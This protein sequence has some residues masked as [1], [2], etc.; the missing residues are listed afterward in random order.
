MTENV[1]EILKKAVEALDS[2]K[3][4]ECIDYCEQAFSLEP[5]DSNVKIMKAVSILL[6]YSY[7][8]AIEIKNQALDV[9]KTITNTESIT[10]E[11]KCVLLDSIFAYKN[12]WEKDTTLWKR[13]S[14]YK[15]EDDGIFL[16]IMS[17]FFA[18]FEGSDNKLINYFM[19]D[20]SNLPWLQSSPVYLKYVIENLKDYNI[21]NRNIS[22]INK[23]LEINKEKDG[24]VKPLVEELESVFRKFRK[25]RKIFKIIKWCIIGPLLISFISCIISAFL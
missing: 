1:K 13:Y 16:K 22:F 5:E 20:V 11:Y 21:R 15:K 4:T 19:N 18:I 3:L 17:F 14:R 23:I 6:A 10:E 7:C 9:L 12:V 24:E 25:R 8:D 2:S